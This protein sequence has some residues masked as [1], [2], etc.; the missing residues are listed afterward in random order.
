MYEKG[1]KNVMY[2]TK[3]EKIALQK[4][5]DL[6][7]HE[8]IDCGLVIHTLNPWLCSSPDGIVVFNKIYSKVL[9]IKCPISCQ[10]LTNNW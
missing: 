10:K 4:Y 8:V 1:L 6:Y 9:E 3:N 2:R 7:K 5:I